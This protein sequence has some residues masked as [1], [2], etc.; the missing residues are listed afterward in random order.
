MNKPDLASL[1]GVRGA[2]LYGSRARGDSD[3]FSDTDIAVFADDCPFKE[4]QA[5]RAQ[6]ASILGCGVHNLSMYTSRK[7]DSMLARGSL[8]LW[9]LKLE[10]R[11]LFSRAR[12]L[13]RIFAR[14]RPYSRHRQDLAYYDALLEDIRNNLEEFRLVNEFDLALLFTV[15]RNSCMVICHRGGKPAF[16]R[17]DVFEVAKII[18]KDKLEIDPSTYNY[19]AGWKLWYNRA[20]PPRRS[21]PSQED[22]SRLICE[23]SSVIDIGRAMCS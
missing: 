8:F 1:G 7:V 6:L 16:G 20:V 23:V 12:Y 3:S 2:I 4:I 15:L 18:L 13:E 17:Q 9:H 5:L 10:G 22:M 19:L 21:L 14:L 11:P